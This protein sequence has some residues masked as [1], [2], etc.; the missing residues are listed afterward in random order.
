M[1]AVLVAV[2]RSHMPVASRRAGALALLF[3]VVLSLVGS[4]GSVFG[5]AAL[6]ADGTGATAD[7]DGDGLANGFEDLYPN[8]LNRADADTDGDGLEDPAED[9]DG[10]GLSNLAEQMF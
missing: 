2:G 3:A 10:D 6:A 9:P 8:V 4:T 1:G 7:S 5:S